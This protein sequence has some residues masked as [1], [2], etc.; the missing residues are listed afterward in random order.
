MLV[1]KKIEKSST[2]DSKFY[3]SDFVF[4]E[5]KKIFENTWQFVT[6]ESNLAEKNAFP[7]SYLDKF[8]DEPL[9]IIKNND[10]VNCFSNV[11]THRGHIINEKKW[12]F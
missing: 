2:I 4:F 3:T 10:S 6:H 9:V 12:I 8:I 1:N 5:S 11:C 7:F